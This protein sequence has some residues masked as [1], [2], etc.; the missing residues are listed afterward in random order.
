[1]T[2]PAAKHNEPIVTTEQDAKKERE[3]S[4]IEFP[5]T[6]LD[7]AV[8]LA[9]AVH[10]AGNSCDWAQLGAKLDMAADG[11]GFRQRLMAAKT[12]GL[13][14]YTS[15]SVTLT[16]LGIQINDPDQL[17]AAK[18]EAFLSVP[19]YK[20]VYE[21]FRN[22]TLPGADGLENAMVGLGVA[23]KQKDKARQT[24]QRSATEAGFFGYG[25]NR[26]VMPT[27]KQL[28]KTESKPQDANDGDDQEELERGR[29]GGGGGGNEPPKY[30]PFI[31]GLLDTLPPTSTAKTEWTLQGRQDWL[32]TAAGIFNL[33]YKTSA[34]DKGTVTVSV[35]APKN[36]AN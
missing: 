1:M 4:K 14:T 12:F 26:L 16:T 19:L 2:E 23:K 11:G 17:A 3:R 30:H 27:V 6:A 36:S 31:V 29:R 9:K 28:K 24:F 22:G 35:D 18:V 5:Y 20:S 25:P 7:L 8:I 15:R 34:D 21:Q 13:I 33:I 32:Q 10:D